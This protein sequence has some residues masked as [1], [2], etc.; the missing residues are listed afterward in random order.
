MNRQKKSHPGSGRHASGRDALVFVIVSLICVAFY[1]LLRYFFAQ[2][3][4]V[5]LLRASS[6]PGAAFAAFFGDAPGQFRP[7]TKAAYFAMMHGLFGLNAVAYHLVSLVIHIANTLLV[8]VL[9]QR[10][11]VP[12]EAAL[13]GS[14]LF[15]L[16]IAFFHV[17]AWVSCI[18]Q[19]GACFLMFVAMLFGL[20]MI[21]K[22]GMVD[23]VVSLAAYTLSLLCMEQGYALPVLLLIVALFGLGNGGRRLGFGAGLRLFGAHVAITVLYLTFMIG[24]KGVPSSGTYEFALR[25]NVLANLV[26]YTGWFYYFWGIL[27]FHVTSAAGSLAPTHILLLAVVAHHLARRRVSA[28]V[29]GLSFVVLGLMPVLFLSEHKFLL[30]TYIPAFG[31]IYLLALGLGDVFARRVM[32]KR[33]LRAAITVGIVILAGA[34]SVIMVRRNIDATMPD[35]GIDYA[36]SFVIRR[37]LVAA[38]A[39]TDLTERMGDLSRVERI[40]MIYGREGWRRERRW[41]ADNVILALGGGDAIRLFFGRV[42]LDIEWRG[43]DDPEET[44]DTETSRVYL[45]DDY[46]SC[47]SLAE[48]IRDEN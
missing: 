21:D 41:N 30:H 1:P 8:L 10:L 9:L 33:R 39:R 31:A 35:E 6:G 18:Q 19:L 12:R 45:Y 47:R 7:L 29:F 3:D 37:A 34:L 36:R 32:T 24:W 5:L 46:G 40:Y 22:S 44:V 26:T 43:V 28:V 13:V 4:F 16:S 15:G 42:D 48:M 27:P 23:R 11:R 2:D 17:I 14:A 25:A 20:R 38:R